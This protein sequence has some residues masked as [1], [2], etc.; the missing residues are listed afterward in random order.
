MAAR[1]R[2]RVLLAAIVLAFTR[3]LAT[4]DDELLVGLDFGSE[5]IKIAAVQGTSIDIVLNEN[6]QRKSMAAIA[7]PDAASGGDDELRL[8]GEAA[9]ARPHLALQFTRELLGQPHNARNV[10]GPH[11]FPA[12]IEVDP[13]RGAC[14]F[15]RSRTESYSAEEINAMLLVYVKRL[16]QEHT[17]KPVRRC[18][19]T[20]PNFFADADRRA[21]LAAAR[22]AGL[23]VL[24][25]VT[26]GLAVALKYA[27][28][29][30]QLA[31]LKGM[32]R[33]LFYDMGATAT[34]A[35][36]VEFRGREAATPPSIRAIGAAWDSSLG[37]AAFTNH[38]RDLLVR[39][40]RVLSRSASSSA[41][42]IFIASRYMLACSIDH[43]R[44]V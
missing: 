7:F 20:V 36:V 15:V 35:T 33:V 1:A 23:E 37:G 11:Y 9:M 41:E 29:T 26:D 30:L 40:R 28:D 22:I 19:I 25:L 6:S 38:L 5:W 16:V 27:T 13:A 43:A 42:T 12:S 17:G 44:M 10:Y 34:Q 2:S 21:L 32:R 24:S 3:G 31:K 14:R 8:F 18:V 39:R 4:A